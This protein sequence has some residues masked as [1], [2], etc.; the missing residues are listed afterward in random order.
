[1]LII[2]VQCSN[3]SCLVIF[4]FSN[5]PLRC[6]SSAHADERNQWSVVFIHINKECLY[7]YCECGGFARS[8]QRNVA[9]SVEGVKLFCCLETEL[10]ARTV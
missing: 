8:L 10:L 5:V 1:M 3:N 9:K 7:H 6:C 2:H 4:S